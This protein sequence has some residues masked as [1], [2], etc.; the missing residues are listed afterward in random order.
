MKAIPTFA[1][2]ACALPAQQ[3]NTKINGPMITST[4]KLTRVP[5]S[6]DVATSCTP[7]MVCIDMVTSCAGREVKYGEYVFLSLP[8]SLDFRIHFDTFIK[9]LIETSSCYDL[10]SSRSITPPLCTASPT[11]SLPR[12]N[13]VLPTL[14]IEKAPPREE[15]PWCLEKPWMCA[16]AG[17]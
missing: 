6:A 10:C 14:N 3:S 12:F 16:P 8:P 2:P 4:P 9:K 5:M 17:W 7:R 15:K 1:M 13:R 11:S